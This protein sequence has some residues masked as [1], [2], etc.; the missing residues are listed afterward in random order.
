MQMAYCLRLSEDQGEDTLRDV[1][2]E[3]GSHKKE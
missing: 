2:H 1:Y 3:H